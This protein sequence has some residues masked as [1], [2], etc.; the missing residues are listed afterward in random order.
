MSDMIDLLEAEAEAGR[1]VKQ[2]GFTMLPI[3][4]F[5]IARNADIHVEPKDSSEPGVSGFLIRVGNVFGIQ[6]ARHIANEGFI[7]FTVAHELGHYYLPGHP[8]SL[9]PNGD[10]C[11]RSHSGFISHDRYERQADQFASALL[12]PESLFTDALDHAGQGFSAIQTLATLCKTSITATAIRFAKYTD[13]PVA[14]IVT[15]GTHVEYCFLSERLK[16][17]KDLEWLKKGDLIAPKSATAA[18]NKAITNIREAR[19]DDGCCWLDDWFDGA[20]HVEMNEDVVGLGSYGK[21]LTI[22]F[23]DEAI[24]DDEDDEDDD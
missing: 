2:H 9:F 16:D 17:M 8:E 11:H 18:F 12:M 19:Q 13:D 14:V 5:A 6:Y 15:G 1:V 23:T 22:L 20:P 4:P 10:G 24:D 7:R 3:C 21:T